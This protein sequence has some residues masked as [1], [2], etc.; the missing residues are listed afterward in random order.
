MNQT[1][2]A[3][4]IGELHSQIESF[5]EAHDVYNWGNMT[6]VTEKMADELANDEYYYKATL[7]PK[8]TA[9]ALKELLV[10]EHGVIDLF[11]NKEDIIELAAQDKRRALTSDEVGAIAKRLANNDCEYGISWQTIRDIT[12]TVCPDAVS[13][14][15]DDDSDPDEACERDREMHGTDGY[16]NEDD[17]MEDDN[18][19]EYL[20]HIES[21]KSD[22][23]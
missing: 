8:D 5:M 3:D 17:D 6:I 19:L 2:K 9:S 11:W 23:Q 22:F 1:F 12:L 21:L 14:D 15:E 10:D 16:E 13:M 18:G 20:R 7:T 4:T